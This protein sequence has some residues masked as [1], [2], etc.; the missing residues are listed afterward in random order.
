MPFVFAVLCPSPSA[1]RWPREAS[2]SP[3]L[4]IS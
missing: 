2:L 4:L 3:D 1:K